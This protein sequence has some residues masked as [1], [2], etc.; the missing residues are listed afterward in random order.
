MAPALAARASSEPVSGIE[1][2]ELDFGAFGE[3]G[4]LID[5]KTAA[6]TRAFNVMR[7]EQ[8]CNRGRTNRSAGRNAVEVASR[9]PNAEPKNAVLR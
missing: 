6:F 5:D 2:Q 1:G 7:S 3:I 8:H 9:L 4:R